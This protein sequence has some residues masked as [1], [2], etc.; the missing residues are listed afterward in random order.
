ME[1]AEGD[2]VVDAVSVTFS[3]G[4]A[5]GSVEGMSAAACRAISASCSSVNRTVSS[6]MCRPASRGAFGL[7]VLEVFSHP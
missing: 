4:E 1:L 6:I 2:Q 3:Q 7:W 5:V